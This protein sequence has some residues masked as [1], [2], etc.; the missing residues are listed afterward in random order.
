MTAPLPPVVPVSWVL[1]HRADVVLADA[2]WYLDGRSGRPAYDAGHLPGAV[3]VDL[4]RWLAG[5]GAPPVV[6]YC[7]SG[8]TA[9]HTLL[10]LEHAGLPPGRLYPGSW[11]QWSSD[12]DR[13]VATGDWFR[14]RTDLEPEPAVVTAATRRRHLGGTAPPE[15]RSRR[16]LERLRADL[17]WFDD[18]GATGMDA[19]TAQVFGAA[20]AFV[21]RSIEAHTGERPPP[22]RRARAARQD[23]PQPGLPADQPPGDQ[24]PG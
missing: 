18:R 23:H 7:G 5:P 3:F 19:R 12:P 16:M 4:D 24:V 13:P 1:E 11:S 17:A 14:S 20:R 10:A 2:R 15:G 21:A 9:C 6:S 22:P 8:V